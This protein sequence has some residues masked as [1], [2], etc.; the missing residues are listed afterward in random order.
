MFAQTSETSLVSNNTNRAQRTRF[1]KT[2][3][4]YIQQR[5][6]WA[7]LLFIGGL[8]DRALLAA[9]TVP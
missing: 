8:V 6:V 4:E 7:I 2:M 5:N 9:A 1:S 3:Q